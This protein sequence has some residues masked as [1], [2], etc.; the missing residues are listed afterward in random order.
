MSDANLFSQ[1]EAVAMAKSV[2]ALHV[3]G[4]NLNITYLNLLTYLLAEV[5]GDSGSFLKVNGK[6]CTNPL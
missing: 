4:Q 6:S 2:P 5:K 3:Q 1:S